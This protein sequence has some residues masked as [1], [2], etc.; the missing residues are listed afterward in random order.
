MKHT[1]GPWKAGHHHIGDGWRVFVQHQADDD[2]HDAICD[3]ETWQTKEETQ[4][5]AALMAASP[6]LLEACKE[7]EALLWGNPTQEDINKAFY[8][9]REA[10]AEVE[11]GE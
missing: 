4:A 5:N 1:K 7:V 2:Q 8:T 3:I 9:V 10:I 11:G 6:E